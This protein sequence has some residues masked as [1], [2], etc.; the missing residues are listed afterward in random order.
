MS[1]VSDTAKNILP[2]KYEA[3]VGSEFLLS[4]FVAAGSI[5]EDTSIADADIA[6]KVKCLYKAASGDAYY[7]YDD[8]TRILT[9]NVLP[10]KD[11]TLTITSSSESYKALTY[12]LS[13]RLQRNSHLPLVKAVIIIY[14]P[15]PFSSGTL[16]FWK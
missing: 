3:V 5:T 4:D 11:D 8:S 10:T 12:K 6:F 2:E 15:Q 9:I 16:L 7:V 14:C 13:K 1:S